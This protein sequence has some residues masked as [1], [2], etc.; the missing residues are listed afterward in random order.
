MSSPFKQFGMAIGAY[1]STF[2]YL[3][4]KGYRSYLVLPVLINLLFFT[5]AIVLSILYGESLIAYLFSLFGYT[6][7]D[8]AEAW[9][10]VLLV[11][12][13]IVQFLIFLSVYKY[14]VLIV[15]APFLA[16]LS[17]KL[18]KELLGKEYPFSWSQ[19]LSDIG[20]ALVI[21][22]WNLLRELFLTLVLT[23]LAFFPLF[24]IVSP[25]LILL[26]QGYFYGYGIMDYNAERWRFGLKQTGKWMWQNKGGVT[27]IGLVF[28]FL[29]MI[30]VLGWIFAP[31]WAVLAGTKTAVDIHKAELK[32]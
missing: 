29:F 5:T 3:F 28:H 22:G 11:V 18:E 21:N 6:L 13:Y 31:V 17:E 12:L 27:G 2:S 1:S 19:F 4:K 26:V 7:T 8:F 30:P 15:L 14:L 10:T 16:F 23:V 9:S 20:R 32:R 25:F 24:A